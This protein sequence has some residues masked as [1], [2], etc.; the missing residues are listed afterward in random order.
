MTTGETIQFYRKQKN[1]SQEQLGALL[2]VSRQTVSLWE[3]DQTVPTVENLIRLK[4]I[5]GVSVDELLGVADQPAPQVKQPYER[6]TFHYTEQDIRRVNRISFRT[7]Y[8]VTVAVNVFLVAT[9][10][11]LLA[12]GESM[13][14]LSGLLMIMFT[15]VGYSIITLVRTAKM[16]KR[17]LQYHR[18]NKA[19]TE[20]AVYDD[21]LEITDIFDG[22]TVLFKRMK[23]SEID[24]FVDA[25]D[26]LLIVR[27]NFSSIV[28]KNELP[29][30]SRF[31]LMIQNRALSAKI[32]TAPR[33]YKI[34]SNVLCILS[35]VCFLTVYTVIAN[36][37][38]D[39]GDYYRYDWLML[40]F[41]PVPLLCLLYGIYLNKKG[42]QN[43]RTW[44]IGL[45]FLLMH[46]MLSLDS[47]LH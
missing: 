11:F 2:Y 28:K 22:E 20:F 24:R 35:V 8:V 15:F 31:F 38:V 43:K 19:S 34:L 7:T 44:I 23:Y 3:K 32:D 4:E 14:S 13:S 18:D 12:I 33:Q 10:I 1:M 9:L 36:L 17:N 5:F 41:A 21:Y 25:G 16:R 42:Y 46:I 6:Y 45:S 29:P 40:P 30:D 37:A 47:L 27:D 26:Y 39:T